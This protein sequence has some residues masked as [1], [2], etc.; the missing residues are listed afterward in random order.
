MISCQHEPE[1]HLKIVTSLSTDCQQ[2]FET[3][4]KSNDEVSSTASRH[5]RLGSEATLSKEKVPIV[6]VTG[7][8]DALAWDGPD[9]PDDPKNWSTTRKWLAT[10]TIAMFAFISPT[11]SSMIAP[12]LEQ[13][14]HDLEVSEGFQTSL[15]LSIFLIAFAIGPLFLGPMS[16][17]FGRT[18]VLQSAFSFFLVFCLACGFAKTRAQF[19]VF[20]IIAGLGGSAPLAIGPGILSDLWRPEQRGKAYGYYLVGPLLS[21]ALAPIFGGFIAE[22]TTWRWVFW[23]TAIYTGLAQGVGVFV[24]RETYAPVLLERRAALRLQDVERAQTEYPVRVRPALGDVLTKALKRPMYLLFTQ[25]IVQALALFQLYNYG[26]VYILLTTFPTVWTDV[27]GQSPA[28]GGL[29]YLSIGLGFLVASIIAAP[30]NDRIYVHLKH[31]RGSGQ[32]RPEYRVP[33]MFP[34][35]LF[36]VAGLF[37]YGWT[38][39]YRTHWILPNIGIFLFSTGCIVSYQCAQTYNIDCYAKHAASSLAAVIMLR[40]IAGFGF[41]LFAPA[42]YERLGWGW[43]NSLLGFVAIGI[44][45]TAPLA[46]WFFGESLRQR[47]SHAEDE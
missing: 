22:H 6:V 19:L 13:V 42:M 34:A 37:M 27:Y 38:V 11:A 23:S 21:P 29:N 5:E 1:E 47:S 41:P 39:Q 20:R 4:S 30:L 2:E 26:I 36:M 14:A 24:L 28:I 9:D 15:L 46:F 32:G 31:T 3:V 35:S 16:E 12:A 10:I 43:G 17:V 40:S 18:K 8:S 25:P 33:M 44:G 7:Q 45:L